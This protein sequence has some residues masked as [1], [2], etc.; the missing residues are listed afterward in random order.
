MSRRLLRLV[1]SLVLIWVTIV[2]VL[3]LLERSMIFYPTRY[4]D[5][6]WD[7]ELVVRSSGCSIEDC[8]FE[9]DDGVSLH[10]WWCRPRESAGPTEG[11]VVL[12]FHGNAGNLSYRADMMLRLARELPVQ[13]V[14]VDYRGYGRSDGR[15][16][17]DGLY[18]DGRAAW[19]YLT[20]DRGIEP[21]R[22]VILGKSLGG[23]VAV[24]LASHVEPA[25][26]IVQSSFTSVRDMARRHFPFVPRALIRTR[27]DSLAKIGS[28]SCPKLFVHSPND[29]IVPYALGRRLFDAA[30]GPKRFH[31]V[32]GARHNDTYLVGGAAYYAALR[33][34][35]AS[36]AGRGGSSGSGGSPMS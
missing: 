6:L 36:C 29:E 2:V 34:F 5:G 10:A 18:R 35:V 21:G 30:P 3:A 31:V 22:V 26:L 4:P 17:E 9:T 24:D 28:V 32:E 16:S 11:M 13:V 33:E 12:W 19:R 20:V 1:I 23:A 7:T 15:P 27:M 14:I 8:T 25:G